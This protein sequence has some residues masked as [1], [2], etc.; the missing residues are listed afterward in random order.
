MGINGVSVSDSRGPCDGDYYFSTSL[1]VI[2]RLI[3]PFIGSS[4][5]SKEYRLDTAILTEVIW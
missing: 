3:F 5:V 1:H 2:S 4:M